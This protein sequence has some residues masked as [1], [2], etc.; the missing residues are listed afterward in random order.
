MVYTKD[1]IA[2]YDYA[3]IGSGPSGAV[4]ARRLSE[5]DTNSS[6]R[7]L[8][9]GPGHE[10]IVN[11]RIPGNYF[12]NKE[13]SHDWNY[14]IVA[15]KGCNN[16]IIST[17]RTRFLGGCSTING[18]LLIRGSKADYDRIVA[19]GNPGWSWEEMLPYFKASETF[20][21]IEWHQSDLT[22][23]GTSGPLHAEPYPHAPISEKVL[24]SFIDSGFE[25]KPDMFVQGDYEGL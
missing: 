3:V 20:H 14:D 4:A 13:K 18:T 16:R 1:D 9:A 10:E 2:T 24:E 11:G 22:V 8:E 7:L 17:P 23:H 12:L 19:M 5:G 6:V 15:Q 25:Y 21:P